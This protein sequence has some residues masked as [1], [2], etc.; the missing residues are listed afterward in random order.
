MTSSRSSSS[1]RARWGAAA[2]ALAALAGCRH[3][4]PRDPAA[5]LMAVFPVQNA[6]GGNAPIH[7]L[8]EALDAALVDRGLRVVPRRDLDEVLA[9]HRIRFTGGVDGGV[10][11]VLREELGVDAV[12]VPTLELYAPAA[13]PKVSL[14]VRLVAMGARPSVLWG[15]E[16]ARSGDDSPGLL[17]LGLVKTVAELEKRVVAA[18]ARSV[19]RYVV[20]GSSGDSCGSAGRFKPRRSFR[21]PEL[22]D[23]GRQVIA[24][25][26][27]ANETSRRGAGEVVLEQFV[28][29]LARS[30]AFE[31]LDPGVVRE[32]LLANR[33]V[34][35]G[36]VSV[37]N[38]VAILDLLQ[39]DLVLSG[40]IQ[41]YVAP[42][43]GRVP[44]KVQF[45][46]YVLDRYTGELVWSSASDGG[47]SDGVFF[48]GA[49]RVHTASA[50]S[51]RMVR[52]VVDRIVGEREL[53]ASTSRATSSQ[54]LR[55]SHRRAQFPRGTYLRYR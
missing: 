46:A 8:T 19:A 4:A 42:P 27:F 33:I 1:S 41:V 21:A 24:V 2:V 15:D 31:V 48:F 13:P 37:D 50:L 54:S 16:V 55:L 35:E 22:D 49:G 10:A 47:G 14:A 38:A 7:A 12:L 18:V 6:S 51:C 20:N 26:P 45:T 29:E 36:G 40:D 23:V 39:A 25:L 3:S 44:P 5:Q 9:R 30:G 53:L 52:G 17:G 43:G 28:A 11:K 34:L 32:E